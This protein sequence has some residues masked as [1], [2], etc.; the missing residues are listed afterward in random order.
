MS[1]VAPTFDR[2]DLRDRT[3][4][5]VPLAATRPLTKSDRCD[6]PGSV[7]DARGRRME[8]GTCGVE[9]LVRAWIPAVDRPLYFCGHH[10][11]QHEPH[12]LQL[13]AFVH[14]ERD[15]L[16]AAAETSEPTA[17]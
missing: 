3:G 1:A 13:G 2:P 11:R 14:D 9:A 15:R 6:A 17:G 8:P 5:I 16:V 7:P 4:R 12:L 10:F